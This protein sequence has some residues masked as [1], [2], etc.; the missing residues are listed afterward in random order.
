MINE[1][2][3]RLD[4]FIDPQRKVFQDPE[5]F[6]FNTDTRLLAQFSHIKKEKP[7]WISERTTACS[8]CTL[9]SSDRES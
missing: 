5:H 4:Y 1:K 8:L 3:L 7:F 2:D 9:R 6:C